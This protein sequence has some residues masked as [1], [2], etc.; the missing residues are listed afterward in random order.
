MSDPLANQNALFNQYESE[1]CSKSTD[2]SRKVQ[3]LSS[4]SAGKSR[5]RQV[6]VPEKA[7]FAPHLLSGCTLICFLVP[8]TADVRRL[9]TKE[10]EAELREADQIVMMMLLF[11]CIFKNQLQ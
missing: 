6:S 3:A 4:F 5:S 8:R 9:R 11:T 7:S 2:I 10:I 1:Y